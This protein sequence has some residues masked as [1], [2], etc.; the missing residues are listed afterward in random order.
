MSG[1]LMNQTSELN[2]GRQHRCEIGVLEKEEIEH[3]AFVTR[4]I[5]SHESMERKIEMPEKQMML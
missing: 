1:I 3:K 5:K 4:V 2:L